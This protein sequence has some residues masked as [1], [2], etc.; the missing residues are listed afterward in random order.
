MAGRAP[1]PRVRGDRPRALTVTGLVGPAAL[2]IVSTLI[3]ALAILLVNS[4][5]HFTGTQVQ[6][7]LTFEAYGRFVRDPFYADVVFQEFRLALITTAACLVIGYPSAYAITKIRRP[8]WVI[9]AYILVFSPLLTSSIVRAYG[10]LIILARGGIVNWALLHLHLAASPIRLIFNFTGVTIALVHVLLPFTVFPI[11]SVLLRMD[12]EVREAAADLGAN[13]LQAF[14][15]VTWPLSFP[16]VYAA[17]QL[18]FILAMNAYV[19][20]QLLGGGRV[21]VLPLLIYQNISD[22]NW[23]LAAV[24]AIALIALVWTIIL[25]STVVFRKS[26]AVAG[27]SA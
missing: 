21:Q 4:A 6:P 11:L 2:F 9:V 19:T 17:A 10:W 13:R 5:F 18:T 8:G 1:R 14:L 7:I 25:V 22:L 26:I 15:R 16:G 27:R 23:P 12:P 20:P 24:E 3:T